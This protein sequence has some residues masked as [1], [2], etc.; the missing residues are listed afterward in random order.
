[1]RLIDIRDA[2]FGWSRQTTLFR[3]ARLCIRSGDTEISLPRKERTT[4]PLRPRR[5]TRRTLPSRSFRGPDRIRTLSP[6]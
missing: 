3:V 5:S 1:M 2:A 6:S 4:C